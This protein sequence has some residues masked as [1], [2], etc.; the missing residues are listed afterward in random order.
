MKLRLEALGA[1]KFSKEELLDVKGGVH[2]MPD[3]YQMPDGSNESPSSPSPIPSY[4]TG[5]GDPYPTNPF[6][7]PF[8]DPTNSGY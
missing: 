1:T 4:P 6:P 5:G 8:P 3:T 7:D 2:E